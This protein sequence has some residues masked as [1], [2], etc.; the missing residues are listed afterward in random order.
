[1][2]QNL[3]AGQYFKDHPEKILGAVYTHNPN[4]GKLLTNRF[5]KAQA[6]VR[7][8]I[9]DVLQGIKVMPANRFEHV[10]QAS[11]GEQ[12]SVEPDTSRIKKAIAATKSEQRRD[13]KQPK[14][15]TEIQC[16]DETIEKYNPGISA[17]EMKVWVTYQVEEGLFDKEVIKG[18]A[19]DKYYVK[20][21]DYQKWYSEGLLAYNGQQYVPAVLYYSGNIYK[22]ITN[23]KANKETII[24]K[25]G[26]KGYERQLAR[27]EEAKPVQLV[28][29][30]DESRK[31]Y[32][33]PFDSFWD[34]IKIAELVDGTEVPEDYHISSIFYY[35]YLRDLPQKELVVEGKY[36]SAYEIYRYW[37][38]KDR[39]D[40]GTTESRKAAIRRNT[41]LIGNLLFD[42]F[43]IEALREEDK[44]RIAHLWNAESN[45]YRDIDYA[46]IPI[47]LNISRKFKGG[48]LEVRAAQREG[49][50]FLN[51]RGTGIVAYD[52]GVGKTMTAILAIS[53]GF[54]KGLF[55]RPLVVVPQKVYQ[56]WIG[57]IIGVYAQKNIKKGKK[58]IHKAGDL[59]SEGI[60]P[61]TKINDYD[62]LG[63]KFITRAVDKFGIAQ[64][65]EA[66]SITMVTYEGLMKIGFQ[67]E[68]EEALVNRIKEMLSQGESGR[69]KAI[70][71]QQAEGWVDKAIERTEIDIEEMGIDAIFVDEGHNFRNLFMEVKGDVG[72]NGEREKRN[73]FSGQGGTPSSRAIKLFMLNSYIQD[74]N[75][76]RNTFALTATPFTN[77]ATEIY[78]IMAMYDI[79]G[80][81]EFGVFNLAQFCSKFIDETLESAWTPAG[82]FDIKA[83]I[84]GYNNLP[85]LQSMIFRAINYKTGEEAKIKRPEKVIIP[86]YSDEKGVPLELDHVVDSR[87]QPTADQAKWL[88]EIRKFASKNSEV[89]RSSKLSDYYPED[90]S[91]SVPG[92][93]LIALNASRA[94]TF[95]PYALKLGG[96]YVYDMEKIDAKKFVEGSPKLHYVC[97]CI[98]TVKQYHEAAGTPVSGQVIY[99]DRGTE[100][101]LHIKQYLVEE[102]GYLPKEVE[103]FHGGVSK[104]KREKIKEGFLTNE[105]KIIIGSSTMREGVDLQKYG[106]VLYNCYLDWN[107]TDHHQLAGRIWRFGNKFSHVRIVVP[108]IENSSDIFTWQKLSE[109]MSRLNTIWTRSG[110]SKLFE[111]SELNAEELKK[112]LIND[113]TELA[114]WEVEEVAGEIESQLEVA[115]GDLEDL[116]SAEPIKMEFVELSTELKAITKE[117]ISNPRGLRYNVTEE[118]RSNLRNMELS[119][120]KS[121]YRIVKAYA[122]LKEYWSATDYRGKVDKHVKLKKRIKRIEENILKKNKLSLS[123]D[124]SPL[125]TTFKDKVFKLKEKLVNIKSE[126]NFQEILARVTKEKEEIEAN[127]KPTEERVNEFKRLNYLLQCKFDIQTCDIYGRIEEAE[128]GKSVAVINQPKTKFISTS[129]QYQMSKLL[130]LMMPRHQQAVVK[131]I[132]QGE[133]EEGYIK[134]VLQP[135]EKQIE[136]IPKLYATEGT[137]LEDKII[138]AH[139]FVGGNDFYIAEWDRGD[140]I[141]GYAVLNNDWQNAEWGTSSLAEWQS[142]TQNRIA[143]TELDFFWEPKPF[144]AIIQKNEKSDTDKLKE[145]AQAL[146]VAM[147]FAASKDQKPLKEALSA[148]ETALEFV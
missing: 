123:D 39:F 48:N 4:T 14:C 137:K 5:G 112:G 10:F 96:E 40:R 7:G 8:T 74:K 87:L 115:K 72:A 100:F 37:L 16:L 44:A 129:E 55:K 128:S 84:R 109:K 70:I 26:Q 15:S 64:T 125:I 132:L 6:E 133:E 77:R 107:P 57:E 60:L 119:D 49:V 33:S 131:G 147:E 25:V 130:K 13:P 2:K 120:D 52:V 38:Q 122:R 121:L 98:K 110:R 142:I 105:I 53:D 127:R 63:T 32:L 9:E 46:K 79:A 27:L 19:W 76:N 99:S 135:L 36:T 81:K 68:T 86:L 11:A 29:G 67:G 117:A 88:D 97:Q 138:H 35:F 69:A 58:I 113:P 34:K 73:F 95:S 41:T 92:Q 65:V 59:I 85:A 126:E 12:I 51:H 108:L 136:Q 94:V 17:E 118:Q 42:R 31:L 43:L 148:L 114:R 62:N 18:N 103:I 54:T 134:Q 139:L 144:K 104:G 145:A 22:A 24:L 82:K 89:R 140:L 30:N 28:I 71:E 83:V 91:G 141:F 45:H 20:K 47:G 1:M 61:G 116:E 75:R 21:P 93:V 143:R 146:R 124:F 56:K 3:F 101:F 23:L 111:E 80:L 50:G 90:E 102:V 78:S 106:T 66:Y